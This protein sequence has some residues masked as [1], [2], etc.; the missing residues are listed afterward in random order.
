LIKTG[1]VR[2]R[3][4]VIENTDLVQMTKW[5]RNN[6]KVRVQ[7]CDDDFLLT[8]SDLP[9]FRSTFG[10]DLTGYHSGGHLGNLYLPAVQDGLVKLFS[11]KASK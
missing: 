5:L 2:N 7:I 4:E 8:P 10:G 3:E 6:P 11:E 9:W 1:R